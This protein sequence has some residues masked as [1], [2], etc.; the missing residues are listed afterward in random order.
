MRIT[1]VGNELFETTIHVN[2]GRLDP[3]F[4]FIYYL[5]FSI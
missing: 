4:I 3:P 1:L 5:M 2:P